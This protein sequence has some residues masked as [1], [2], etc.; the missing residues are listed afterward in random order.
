MTIFKRL[1]ILPIVFIVACLCFMVRLGE[2]YVGLEHVGSAYA[3][4]DAEA[5]QADSAMMGQGDGT[6]IEHEVG[7]NDGNS[8]SGAPENSGVAD[9]LPWQDATQEDY[10]Y[11][12]V[13][14]DL[15]NDLA[16]RRRALDQREREMATR[17]ALLEAA[18]RELDQKLRELETVQARIEAMMEE[19]TEEQKR[20]IE[21]LVKIYEGMK[22]KEAAR[23]FDTLD[24][25]ILIRVMSQ[26]SERKLSPVLAA[27]N[28][29]RARTVT[30]LLAE[31]NQL[32]DVQ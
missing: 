13:Q 14:A 29:D 2:F 31:K 18:E 22:A 7:I 17:A 11:S 26:M 25:E 21:S 27:M 6:G 28:P 10:T 4:K 32:P 15:Y 19:Q 20:R 23:I 16:E 9:E 5:E 3:A 8:L 24:M 1:R 12:E 30:I